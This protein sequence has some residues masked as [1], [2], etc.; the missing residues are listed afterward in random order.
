MD[1]MTGYAFIEES[2]DQ[3]SFSVELKSLNSRY[4]ETYVN[5]PKVIKNEEYDLHALLKKRFSRGKIDLTVEIYDWIVARPVAIS[6][7]MIKKYYRELRAIHRELGVKEP[8]PLEAVLMLEGIGQRERSSV[9]RVSRTRIHGAIDRVIGMTADM[10]RREGVSIRKDLTAQIASIRKGVA[11]IK[12]LA[13]RN[14]R[15]KQDSLNRR[16]EALAGEQA[17]DVRMLTEIAILADKLD[18]NEEIVR[19]RDHIEKFTALMK[20]TDQMGKKLDFLAQE[21]FREINTIGSKSV[22]ADIAHRAVDMKNHLE[23]I[24]EQ[25]RNVV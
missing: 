18:I 17:A 25:C 19:L 9:S 22:N 20:G 7:A 4:L 11:G 8:L 23:M 15:D 14:V 24:R 16:I 21:M 5:L 10:R 13:K 12:A 3:F 1:S 2:T 6:A